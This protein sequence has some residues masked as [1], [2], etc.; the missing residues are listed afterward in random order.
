[1]KLGPSEKHEEPISTL[2]N[3][4][5]EIGTRVFRIT[6]IHFVTNK[7]VDDR[8]APSR[9]FY[10]C[11]E[12]TVIRNIIRKN[13]S[14]DKHSILCGMKEKSWKAKNNSFG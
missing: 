1:M 2:M 5:V 10:G 9:R 7:S 12:V 3:S 13:N 8:V 14:L 11:D 6:W 4:G